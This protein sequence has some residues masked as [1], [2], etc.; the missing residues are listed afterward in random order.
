LKFVL[1][2]LGRESVV[3]RYRLVKK[4]LNRANKYSNQLALEP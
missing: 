4:G 1:G 2:V 3:S